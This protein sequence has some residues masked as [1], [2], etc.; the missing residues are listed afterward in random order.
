MRSSRPVIP[1]LAACLL[2]CL[3]VVTTLPAAAGPTVESDAEQATTAVTIKVASSSVSGCASVRVEIWVNDVNDL[4]AADVHVLFDPAL[5]QVVDVDPGAPGVQIEPVYTFM[6]PGFVIKR[7]ACNA[8]DPSNPDCPV[9]GRVWYSA[10]QLTPTPPATG[11]G[12]IAAFTLVGRG[13]GLSTLD[14]SYQQL[15]SPVGQVIPATSL[16]GSIG[17]TA[18]A[19]VDVSIAVFNASTARLSWPA[20]PGV[21]GYRLYRA[22]TPYFT[23]AEPPSQVTSALA[24]NDV[25]ALGG[26]G[27]EYY[28]VV[29]AA[30]SSGF[31]S[32]N[33]NR[34]GAFDFALV[35]GS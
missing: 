5:L 17:I 4:Y 25:G 16:D 31:T 1:M 14:I 22:S 15:S 35:P 24:L 19:P 34:T 23:P 28:Y 30:C 13:E 2:F 32:A 10:T 9:G 6:N 33:S 29:K 3:L 27:V 18:P 21:A 20:S 7:V 11:T 8:A 12:P 26:V